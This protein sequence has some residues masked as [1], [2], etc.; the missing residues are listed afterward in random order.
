MLR[1]DP[2]GDRS[3]VYTGAACHPGSE[4]AEPVVLLLITDRTELIPAADIPEHRTGPRPGI[5]EHHH[6]HVVGTD[7]LYHP[8]S[9]SQQHHGS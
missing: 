4:K 6:Q 3:V 7:S 1:D 5:T 2:V 9:Q 8:A